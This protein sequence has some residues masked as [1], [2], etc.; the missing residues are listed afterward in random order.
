MIDIFDERYYR[1]EDYEEIIDC[2]YHNPN[3]YQN[4][5][6]IYKRNDFVSDLM[7][8]VDIASMSGKELIELLYKKPLY[9]KVRDLG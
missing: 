2:L 6:T 4:E 7:E 1:I 8:E 9:K 3:G 5:Y